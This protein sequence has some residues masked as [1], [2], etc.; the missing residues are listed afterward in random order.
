[1]VRADRCS[2][3]AYRRTFAFNCRVELVTQP[4][5][6]S[7]Y[8]LMPFWRS[9]GLGILFLILIL[10]MPAVFGALE[11]TLLVLLESVQTVLEE[12]TSLATPLAPAVPSVP[13]IN[14]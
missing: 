1:M 3:R 4:K 14:R 12:V 7:L 2:A 11:E 8:T 6:L 5:V 10:S 9:I 13:G